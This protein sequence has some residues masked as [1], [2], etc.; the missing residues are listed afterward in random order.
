MRVGDEKLI[1]PVI[2]LGGGGQLAAPAALLRPVF[3][4][5]LALDVAGVRERDHHVGGCDQVFGAQIKRAVLDVAAPRAQLGLTEFMLD[6][7]KFVADDDRYAL[8]TGQNVEK[9]VNLGHHGFVFSDDFVLLQAGQALQAHLQDF[10]RL[11][12][13]QAVQAVAAHAEF[14][15][16]RFGAVVV[17]VD[18][19]AVG[20]A[21]REHLANQLAVPGLL[22]QLGSGDGRRGRVADDGDEFI[23]IGQRHGQAFEHMA[24][25]AGFAQI[26][27]RAARDHFAAVRQK[28]LNQVFQ[29]AQ[30]GL[31]VDQR[32]HV[33][34]E[35][36]L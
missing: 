11:G 3:G 25:L 36:V 8:G 21:A 17:G 13:G 34:A 29:V 6:G 7:A 10:L 9:I 5:R 16:Q 1:D 12:F 32:H 19:A 31:A 33:D 14:F 22:H 28:H 15:F 24:A 18:H 30:L 35:G 27:H 2:I 23:D 4:Q 26:E 20:A